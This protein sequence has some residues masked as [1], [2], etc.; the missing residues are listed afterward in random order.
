MNAQALVASHPVQRGTAQETLA[1]TAK[2]DRT[3]IGRLECAKENPTVAML[4]RLGAA[5]GVSAAEFLTVPRPG[6]PKPK[7]LP[8]G[9]RKQ[10]SKWNKDEL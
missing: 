8:R 1:V 5:L 6:D 4:D 9:R 3:Y 2:V 10:A 7:P